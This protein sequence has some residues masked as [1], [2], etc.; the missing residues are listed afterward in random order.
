MRKNKQLQRF[1]RSFLNWNRCKSKNI[2]A[3]HPVRWMSALFLIDQSRSFASPA[4]Y[5]SAHLEY[6]KQQFSPISQE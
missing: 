1:Q 2:Q 4:L 6:F 5:Y 3:P